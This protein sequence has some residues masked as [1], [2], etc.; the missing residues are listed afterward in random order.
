[1]DRR[2]AWIIPLPSAGSGGLRTIFAHAEELN[3]R[4][5]TNDFFI[6]AGDYGCTIDMN[7]VA[8]SIRSWFSAEVNV[9]MATSIPKDYDAV[10]ATLWT[11][12]YFASIQDISRK[13]YFIQGY[14]PWIYPLGDNY[15]EAKNSYRLGLH[16]ITIGRWLSEKIA[17]EIGRASVPHT[18]FG[19]DLHTYRPLPGS[20]RER[21]VCA[22]YQPDKSWRLPSLIEKA[23]Y[24]LSTLHPDI[25]IY[26]FGSSE[27]SSI[28][29]EC[30]CIHLG[31]VSPRE[32]N[33]LYNKCL[34][35]ICLSCSNPSRLAFEMMAAGLPA[36]ELR[37]EMTSLDLPQ[38]AVTFCDASPHSLVESITDLIDHPEKRDR[39][40]RTGIE[41]MQARP[42]EKENSMF[43]DQVLRYLQEDIEEPEKMHKKDEVMSQLERCAYRARYDQLL[44]DCMP[45]SAKTIR[46]EAW[47]DDAQTERVKVFVWGREDQG[48]MH[49]SYLTCI[50][51]GRF[52]GNVSLPVCQGVTNLHFHLYKIQPG[53]PESFLYGFDKEIDN[54]SK[55]P[56]KKLWHEK[57]NI[58]EGILEVSQTD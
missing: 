16:P 40:S 25:T 1:M 21:A 13:I 9:Q 44:F 30:N 46:M 39:M 56:R 14:E 49:E 37:G 53:A 50:S 42:I 45:L 33:E 52:C 11:T 2:I 48:D 24:I 57:M 5:C 17:D 29:K 43:A 18:I 20:E 36:I 4:G 35:G 7:A 31:I 8:E 47:I 15:L 54:M 3:R 23:L 41:Y 38:D 51:S 10:V 22:I 27:Q 55:M 58:R 34:C 28:L 32:L 26:T 6:L 19:A 12:A